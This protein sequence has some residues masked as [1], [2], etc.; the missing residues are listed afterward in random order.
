MKPEK[1]SECGAELRLRPASCPLCGADLAEWPAPRSEPNEDTYQSNVRQL[2]D[3]LK[4]LRDEAQ[5]A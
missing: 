3:E 5:T 4:R 2:R 1:C